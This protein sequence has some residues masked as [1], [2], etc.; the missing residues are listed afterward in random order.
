MKAEHVKTPE[1]TGEV[2][3]PGVEKR[4]ERPKCQRSSPFARENG[5]RTRKVTCKSVEQEENYQK[6]PRWSWARSQMENPGINGAM[7]DIFPF[8]RAP[9]IG[10]L[11]GGRFEVLSH[12]NFKR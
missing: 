11:T 12:Q 7:K 5:G 2:S 3:S 10:D 1:T 9:S 8:K 4:A 6:G